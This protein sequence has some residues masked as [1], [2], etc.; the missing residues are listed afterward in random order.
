[1]DAHEAYAE[2]IRRA[3]ELAILGSCSSLLGWDEQTF[4]PA[5][6]AGHRSAQMGL[7]AGIHHERATD[8]RIG[9]LLAIVESSDLIAEPRSPAAVNVREIAPQ[10]TIAAS[11]CR[12]LWSRNWL[13]P[14]PSRSPSGSPPA[15]RATSLASDP[16]LEKI[17]QLKR[18]ESACLERAAGR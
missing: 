15:R 6:G 18:Q 17:I 5:G 14:P 7:L 3:R 1:M 8:P 16:W 13:A 2:L 10:L 4:M 9:E 11:A 12:A